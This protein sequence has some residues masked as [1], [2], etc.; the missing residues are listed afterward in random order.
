MLLGI[1]AVAPNAIRREFFRSPLKLP[2]IPLTESDYRKLSSV[3][4]NPSRAS[5]GMR[6]TPKAALILA[7]EE[8]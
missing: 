2:K 8:T 3:R 7:L 4:L 1:D 6:S 5:T